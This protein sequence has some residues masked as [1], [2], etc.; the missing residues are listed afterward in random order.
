MEGWLIDWPACSLLA[1]PV[2]VCVCDSVRRSVGGVSLYILVTICMLGLKSRNRENAFNY[3]FRGELE[4]LRFSI[5][6]N[7]ASHM[8]PGKKSGIFEEM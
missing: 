5:L 7:K 6:E 2:R 3:I 1:K 8:L 4:I